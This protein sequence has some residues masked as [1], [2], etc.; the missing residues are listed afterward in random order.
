M[1]NH[2]HV[3]AAQ[4]ADASHMRWVDAADGAN[5]NPLGLAESRETAEHRH[6]ETG[7]AVNSGQ[8]RG[9]T[10]RRR[11]A[12]VDE[13]TIATDGDLIRIEL[14]LA[15]AIWAALPPMVVA[16][17]LIRQAWALRDAT[18]AHDYWLSPSYGLWRII[19]PYNSAWATRLDDLLLASIAI[20]AAIGI[21]ALCAKPILRHVEVAPDMV[22]LE[23][24]GW[25][26]TERRWSA[27]EWP[28]FACKH[29]RRG[30]LTP[31]WY[32]FL[33][34]IAGRVW[35]LGRLDAEP[36]GLVE[37]LNHGRPAPALP[38]MPWWQHVILAALMLG[39]LVALLGP[40]ILARLR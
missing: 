25:C 7:H 8:A 39:F 15:P 37:R 35:S 5:W 1:T 6:E 40:P 11:R 13:P 24:R 38:S 34:P 16:A 29:V 22:R 23:Q 31:G 26:S 18:F 30:G 12:L 9:M 27:G 20:L 36:H 28:L 19:T 17:M 2:D 3:K 32:L 14:R 4:K 21:L 33:I 10:S